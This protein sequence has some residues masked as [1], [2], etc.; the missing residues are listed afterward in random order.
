MQVRVNNLHYLFQV[1]REEG[2][3]FAREHGLHFLETSAKTAENVEKA[4][5]MTSRII[6][7][8]IEKGIFVANDCFGI[9]VGPGHSGGEDG[10]VVLGDGLRQGS[11]GTSGG[12]SC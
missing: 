8:N 4:F 2:E 7:D 10:T 1:S 5:E 3:A 11:G 12:C 6:Y 9:K